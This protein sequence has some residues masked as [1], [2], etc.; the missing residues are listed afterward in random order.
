MTPTSSTNL[1]VTASG[2]SDADGHN[3]SYSYAWYLNGA[4][5]ANVTAAINAADTSKG[6]IWTARVTP[7]DG[8]HDGQYAKASVLIANS[9]PVLSGV[10]ILQLH[11]AA[12]IC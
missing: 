10:T 12:P 4:L 1:L 11:P 6:E 3:V 5:T 2:S 9:A 8:Y 7:N